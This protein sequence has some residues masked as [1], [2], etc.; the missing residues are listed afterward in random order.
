MIPLF[1]TV[2]IRSVFVFHLCLL[3]HILGRSRY[4][5]EK[6]PAGLEAI[7]DNITQ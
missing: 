4:A 6:H 2:A 3:L 7:Y 1:A 5:W